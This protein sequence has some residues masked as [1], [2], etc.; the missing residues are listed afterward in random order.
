VHKIGSIYKT[1]TRCVL[2]QFRSHLTQ[3]TFP[4]HDILYISQLM[5]CR[6]STSGC[7]GNKR[8]GVNRECHFAE[9]TIVTYTCRSLLNSKQLMSHYISYYA[10]TSL[11]FHWVCPFILKP[12]VL[13]IQIL[14]PE[15]VSYSINSCSTSA[16]F[17]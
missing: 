6:K 8:T 12:L 4:V 16:H 2:Y 5:L 17:Y 10:S 9:C 15:S 14:T 3:H 11:A 7:C 1:D 13:G